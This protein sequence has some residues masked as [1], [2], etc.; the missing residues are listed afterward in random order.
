MDKQERA[1]FHRARWC[2]LQIS[3]WPCAF[4]VVPPM[5]HLHERARRCSC[6]ACFGA[7]A[8]PCC[9]EQRQ[10]HTADKASLTLMQEAEQ[11][12][13]YI[14]FPVYYYDL[15]CW[16]SPSISGFLEFQECLHIRPWQLWTCRASVCVW[17]YMQVRTLRKE[18]KTFVCVCVWER[19]LICTWGKKP[20]NS[21]IT[22]QKW[23]QII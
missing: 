15:W 14:V 1:I 11:R 7:K 23:R 5:Q 18:S 2:P 6:A 4:R 3:V 22:N 9:G 10:H 20:Q 13:R 8:L 16:K 17:F 12:L 19:D 21:W